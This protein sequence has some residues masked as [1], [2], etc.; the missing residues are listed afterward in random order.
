M[1]ILIGYQKIVKNTTTR[2]TTRTSKPVPKEYGHEK[3]KRKWLTKSKRQ[4][5]SGFYVE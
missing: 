3:A 5:D 4:I 2:T 1:I